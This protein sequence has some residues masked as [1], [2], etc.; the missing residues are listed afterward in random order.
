VAVD[1]TA[2][3]GS[4]PWLRWYATGVPADLQVPDAPVSS[5]LDDAA[6][7]FPRRAAIA[8]LGKTLTYR[9][10]ADAVE[11]FAGALYGLGVRKGDRVALILPN[12]P[13]GII[14]FFATLRLGAVVVQHNPL[15]TPSELR[16]QLADSGARVAIVY[17]G[18]Y[19]R[20]AAAKPGTAVEHVI[21]TSLAEYLSSGKRL[22]LR[23]PFGKVREKREALITELPEDAD[24]HQFS[25]LL[26]SAPQPA[27]DVEISPDRDLA[28]L[29]Y[30][31]GTTGLPKGAMLTHRNLVANAH[32][33]RAW[34]PDV[35]VGN[36]IVLAALPIFHVY[37]LTMCLTMPVLTAATIV[38]LPTFDLGL[39]FSAIDKWR[40]TV[41]PGVPPMYDQ[42]VRSRRTGRHDLR[43]IRTCVSGAM[44]LP[45]E[46]VESFAKVTGGRLVEGYGLTESSPVALANPLD[47]N[48]RPGTIGIP[49][50]STDARIADPEDPTRDMPIGDAGEL[51]V[52]GPQVF[53]GYWRQ[54]RESQ[55]ML[56]D[57]WLHTADIAFMDNDGFV[58]L[59]DRKRDVIMASGFS[60]FPSEIEDVILEHPAVESCAV[61]GVSHYYR[62]ETVK[63]Y[64]VLKHGQYADELELQRFCAARLAAYKVPATF[65]FRDSLPQNMLG[66]VLR[67]VLRDEYEALRARTN[68]DEPLPPR[69]APAPPPAPVAPTTPGTTRDRGF[70]DELERL[71]R[72]HAEGLLTDDEFIAAKARLLG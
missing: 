17:D 13:Q 48:A 58:T 53:R 33:A 5:L 12:C 27:A 64:V 19:T 50:P 20:L 45:P 32:Q 8:F 47:H 41:F 65:D 61:V 10:L 28:L 40:P 34:D 42:I 67:R 63:A 59:I 66:K 62:G 6:R 29:Q 31:G 36:E 11:R 7:N 71:V 55:A 24:V 23:L 4:R 15:Y 1:A 69:P 54:P 68:H 44:R 26:R 30:T 56:H 38:L 49:L 9:E 2:G 52:R 21:V 3:Y 72:L 39:L 60:V 18:A 37:G 35:V 25:K 22:A 43:S 16:H 14:A 70:V 46:L 57:G 51:C